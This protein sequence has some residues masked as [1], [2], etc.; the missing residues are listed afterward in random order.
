MALHMLLIQVEY[1]S[2]EGGN[3]LNITDTAAIVM[4][5][6]VMVTVVPGKVEVDLN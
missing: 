5:N 2:N 6:D 4:H 1:N 3:V